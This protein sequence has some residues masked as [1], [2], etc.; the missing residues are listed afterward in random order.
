MSLTYPCQPGRAGAGAV[1]ADHQV[2][3]LAQERLQPADHVT[4]GRTTAARSRGGRLVLERDVAEDVEQVGEAG[5]DAV[6]HDGPTIL[7]IDGVRGRLPLASRA[8]RAI[9]MP[10]ELFGQRANDTGPTKW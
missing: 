6:A 8:Y 2:A 7:V 4:R 5:H 1:R 9:A 10:G 3:V